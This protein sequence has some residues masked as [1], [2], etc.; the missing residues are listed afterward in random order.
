[1]ARVSLLVLAGAAVN[2]GLGQVAAGL[3]LPLYLDSGGTVLCAAIGGWQVGVAAALA[4]A[5]AQTPF[6]GAASW[7]IV[8]P[9]HVVIAGYA[10]LAA[11][12]GA[13]GG[14]GRVVAA[15]AGLGLIMALV[16]VP[17]AYVAQGPSPASGVG[18]LLVAWRPAT[19]AGE[20]VIFAA[21]TL[22][23][24]LDKTVTLV[25]AAVVLRHLPSGFLARFPLSHR[26]LGD[27][28]LRRDMAQGV[29]ES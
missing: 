29:D 7:L 6:S 11:R 10:A 4:T 14:P 13:F 17:M 12:R 9:V 2:L 26:A 28:G 16:A 18:L 3:A 27:G 5:L 23:E 21:G 22:V 25:A 19:V 20:L 8:A 1:M 24:L 15:G